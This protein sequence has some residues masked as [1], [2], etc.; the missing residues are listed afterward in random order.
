[1][2]LALHKLCRLVLILALLASCGA[3]WF[4]LQSVAWTSMLVE[5]SREVSFV[6]AVKLTF[7]GAHPCA[8]C[9]TIETGRRSEPQPD[10]PPAMGKVE[11]FYQS[12]PGLVPPPRISRR[13]V[14]APLIDRK[15]V[16]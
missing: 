5:R 2:A 7:D 3:H 9:Q 16:V 14:A 1:M 4:V 12:T 13:L 11:I 8:L 15:S 10:A 6:Q